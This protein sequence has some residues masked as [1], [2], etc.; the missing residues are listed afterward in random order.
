M[1]SKKKKGKM[2]VRNKV[3]KRSRRT[4]GKKI[5]KGK[6]GRRRWRRGCK[7]GK[8]STQIIWNR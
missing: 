4:V 3:K 1:V 2:E 5:R 6:S 8:Y 7:G